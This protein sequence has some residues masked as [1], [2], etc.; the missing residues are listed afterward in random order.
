[1]STREVCVRAVMALLVV[2]AWTTSAPAQETPRAPKLGVPAAADVVA[3]WDTTV[4]PDG[5]GLPAGRGT[6]KE[7]R[8]IYDEKCSRCHGPEG[9][10][11]TAEELVGRETPLTDPDTSQTIGSYWP[12]ATTLFDYTRRAMPMDQPGSLTADEV[13]AVSAYLL[14]LNGVIGETDE[15]TAESLAKVQM[16]NRNGF[17]RID[18]K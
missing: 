12:Y 3:R 9:R 10:G 16:P 8:A 4:F 5:R 13:Y 15:L 17:E 1:M 14:Q 11:E 18:A 6:A 2:S 7:G